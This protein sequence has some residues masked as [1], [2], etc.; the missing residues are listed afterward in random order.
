MTTEAAASGAALL[1]ERADDSSVWLARR[2]GIPAVWARYTDLVVDH[3]EGS[4]IVTQDGDRYLDYTCGIGVTN[5]GHA[6]PRVAAAIA[7][8]AGKIIHAQQNI[9]YHKPGLELHERLPR[10]FPNA[11]AAAEGADDGHSRHRSVPVQLGRRGDRGRRQ[12]G[13]DRDPSAGHRRLPRRVPRANPRDDVAHLIGHQEPRPL[14]AAAGQH[15]L[16]A[17]PVS[18]A[19]DRHRADARSGPGLDHVPAGR[20]VRDARVPRGRGRVPGG[21]GARGGR[22]RRSARWIPPCTSGSGGPPWDSAHRRR[23]A[24][25]LR[26]HRALLRDRVVGGAAG[27]RGHGQGHRVRHAALRHPRLA[28]SCWTDSHRAVTAAP[29]AAT[30][31]PARRRSR[32]STYSRA[33]G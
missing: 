2:A 33:R 11:G 7:A 12:A 26:P 25:R 1:D 9:L 32:P 3:G 15:L 6:H 20:A 18:P 24:V 22:I 31:C 19:H 28:A 8:Q 13:Q 14:R 17:V 27:H 21:A 4:W 5:T 16:R 10:Y 23:G 30:R 29:M